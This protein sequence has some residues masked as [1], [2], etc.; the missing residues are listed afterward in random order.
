MQDISFAFLVLSCDKYA[1]LWGG[2]LHQLEKNF[3]IDLPIY[4]AS[5]TKAPN[6]NI[7][8]RL[9][10]TG[11]EV[12]W[13]S[14]F[15]KVLE[16]IDERY[17]F[18]TLEDLYLK[19]PFSNNLFSEACNFIS[20]ST[21]VVKHLK[22]SGVIHGHEMVSEHISKLP[23]GLPYRVTLCGIWDREYLISAIESGENPWQFEVDGSSREASTDG[24]YA[25]NLPIC[26][27]V[28]MV[29]KGF[30]IKK[31]IYWAVK[32]GVPIDKNSRPFK[33]WSQELLSIIKDSYFNTIIKIDH[34]IRKKIVD[35]IK[36]YLVVH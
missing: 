29:E 13:G 25:L 33:S 31:S 14:N 16:R 34:S 26:E 5:N 6:S 28:N 20:L 36:K 22:Y 11:A 3:N 19:S 4:F 32:S 7:P 1:D 27:T 23:V 30:W 9:I 10:L 18:V 24:Y 8:L 21:G 35:S 17:V 12:S 2:Y 15:K